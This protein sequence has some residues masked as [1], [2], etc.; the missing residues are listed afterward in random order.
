MCYA[1]TFTVCLSSLFTSPVLGKNISEVLAK[2]H[3]CFPSSNELHSSRLMCQS[4]RF[5]I[6]RICKSWTPATVVPWLSYGTCNSRRTCFF[7]LAAFYST[8]IAWSSVAF[9]HMFCQ[10]PI[11]KTVESC[12]GRAT[13]FLADLF[14]VRSWRRLSGVLFLPVRDT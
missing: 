12:P 14:P 4:V 7:F 1:I 11:T 9:A 5:G 2:C 8:G 10:V 3:P 13:L 6:R